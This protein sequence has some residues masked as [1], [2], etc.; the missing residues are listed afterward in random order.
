MQR[1][2]TPRGSAPLGDI[3]ASA[4]Q[5]QS[6]AILRRRSTRKVDGNHVLYQQNILTGWD[7]LPDLRHLRECSA[8]LAGRGTL[9]VVAK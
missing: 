2:G 6:V 4:V 3:A 9:S 5:G 1:L 7:Q 8:P